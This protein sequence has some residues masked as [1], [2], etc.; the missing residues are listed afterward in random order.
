MPARI[1]T[2]RSW[3]ALPVVL[4]ALLLPAAS[5]HA[6]LDLDNPVAEPTNKQAGAHSDFTLSFEISGASHIKDL[7]TELPRPSS[8]PLRSDVHR[9][10]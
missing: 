4:S 3:I 9:A 8:M 10:R 2:T 1:A 7:V 5:A 6:A